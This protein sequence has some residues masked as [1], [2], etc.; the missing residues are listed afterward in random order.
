M[1]VTQR[2]GMRCSHAGVAVCAENDI[3]YGGNGRK[4]LTGI[5]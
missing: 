5:E 4:V 1:C 2:N 3:E